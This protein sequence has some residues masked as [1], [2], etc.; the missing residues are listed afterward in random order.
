M[1]NFEATRTHAARSLA[2][3]FPEHEADVLSACPDVEATE[4]E[5]FPP[6]LALVPLPEFAKDVGVDGKLLVPLKFCAKGRESTAEEVDLLRAAFWFI[7]STWE[8]AHEKIH[9]PVHSF[10]HRLREADSRMFDYAWAN[11]IGLYLRRK[12]ARDRQTD[13]IALF[14]ELPPAEIIV[15]HDVDALSKTFEVRFKQSA[16][17]AFNALRLMLG[18]SPLKSTLRMAKALSFFFSRADYFRLGEVAALEEERG[19]R[20]HFNFYGG[21]PGFR[22][23]MKNMILDPAYDVSAERISSKIRELRELGWT[24]GLHQSYDAFADAEL[25]RAQKSKIENAAGI[26]IKSCRQHWLRFSF[27]NTWRAQQDAGFELDTTLGFNDRPGFRSGCA[28]R[29]N[30]VCESTGEKLRIEAI[31][32]VLMDS[33]IY[34]YSLSASASLETAISRWLDEIKNVRGVATVIWHQRVLSPDY[35]WKPGFIELLKQIRGL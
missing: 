7:N 3:Y 32:M 2:R 16:F 17:H 34:D 25:M 4:G 30:P 15:T 18:M 27:E 28:L 9:G 29:Y 19:V 13:E 14:G 6:E 1:T 22:R 26:E 11:R 23:T 24:I 35:G 5:T 31:P 12:I 21:P 8:R 33:Q 20:S 10:A